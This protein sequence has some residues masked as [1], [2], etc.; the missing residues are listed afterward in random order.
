M[1]E[2]NETSSHAPAT[3]Y[4][5][6]VD[7]ITGGCFSAGKA[8]YQKDSGEFLLRIHEEP[9]HNSIYL[10]PVDGYEDGLFYFVEVQK[11]EGGIGKKEIIGEGFY[12]PKTGGD[13]HVH[14]GS[15]FKKLVI[16]LSEKERREYA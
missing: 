7:P 8:V 3:Y 1:E 2:A 14:Y 15:K 12:N 10:R 4:M 13:I 6:W 5:D 16:R 9:E 11:H